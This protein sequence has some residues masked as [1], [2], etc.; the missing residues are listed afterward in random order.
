M[1]KIK[2]LV[3]F[4][5][6]M[7]IIKTLLSTFE[8]LYPYD[9]EC[10]LFWD[11]ERP[12]TLLFAVILSAQC[13]DKRVN[14]VT[15]ELFKIF[16]DLESYVARPREELERIIHST[17][18]Y[19]QKAESLSQSAHKLLIHHNGVLPDNM[20]DLLQLSGVGRKTANVIL[21]NVFQKNEGVVVDTHMKRITYRLGLTTHTD[22]IRIEQDIM[23][24]IPKKQWGIFSHRM[25]QFGRDTC[26][27]RSPKC[28]QCPLQSV[29]KKKGVTS[30]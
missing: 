26:T 3:Y 8:E 22:P 13:T 21:W 25:V 1:K 10:H 11:K 16:S 14:M 20:K 23:K 9:N 29:C 30:T 6:N 15:P 12:W 19:R 17:G 5:E 28:K 7:K 2:I 4:F 18:F 24:L 27:A